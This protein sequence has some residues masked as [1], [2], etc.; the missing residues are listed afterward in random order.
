MSV[1]SIH[2]GRFQ[3]SKTST[4]DH[5]P[6]KKAAMSSPQGSRFSLDSLDERSRSTHLPLFLRLSSRKKSH[7]PAI[8]HQRSRSEDLSSLSRQYTCSR[9]QGKY[10]ATYDLRSDFVDTENETSPAKVQAR[11][12]YGS[13]AVSH[14][15]ADIQKFS[16]LA[17]GVKGFLGKDE[18][19][20]LVVDPKAANTK[21][22]LERVKKLEVM[23][24][25]K[26]T[27]SVD[28]GGLVSWHKKRAT[29]STLA[30]LTSSLAV[31]A[32]IF[33]DQ[34]VNH[35]VS[36]NNSGGKRIDGK[37][38]CNHSGNDIGAVH[39]KG[40]VNLPGP[41]TA[42]NSPK[43][44]KRPSRDF[45]DSFPTW[46]L[47]GGGVEESLESDSANRGE[48]PRL[49]NVGGGA[50]PSVSLSPVPK[51]LAPGTLSLTSGPCHRLSDAV[52]PA[53]FPPV[54]EG[55][56]G[57]RAIKPYSSAQQVLR[58]SRA[59]RRNGRKDQYDTPEDD[60][61]VL[62]LD[63]SQEA[64]GSALE[65]DLQTQKPS[66]R[67]IS[68]AK[69]GG[70]RSS[71]S[72]PAGISAAERSRSLIPPRKCSNDSLVS[73]DS[74][75]TESTRFVRPLGSCDRISSFESGAST[76]TAFCTVPRDLQ[77]EHHEQEAESSHL[78]K[79]L[80]PRSPL[81]RSKDGL[82]KSPQKDQ[83]CATSLSGD[84]SEGS[85]TTLDAIEAGLPEAQ[86]PPKT[87][88]AKKYDV[89]DRTPS[90]SRDIVR[91]REYLRSHPRSP[92]SPPPSA[93]PT[94]PL[95]AVPSG[96][97]PLRPKKR[98][99]PTYLMAGSLK[100][101]SYDPYRAKGERDTTGRQVDSGYKPSPLSIKRDTHVSTTEISSS[102][103]E[104]P[105]SIDVV[106]SAIKDLAT[107]MAARQRQER[108]RCNTA[109][110]QD[111]GKI[112]ERNSVIGEKGAKFIG[113]S[114]KDIK[115]RHLNTARAR[116]END[117]LERRE[118]EYFEYISD[119]NQNESPTTLD[120]RDSQSLSSPPS[121]KGFVP[122]RRSIAVP[123]QAALTRPLRNDSPSRPQ[124]SSN[125]DTPA[126]RPNSI[127][128]RT[129]FFRNVGTQ[130]L[131]LCKNT[132]TAT[133]PRA[134]T[135]PS[136]GTS[137]DGSFTIG[138]PSIKSS[139]RHEV[140]QNMH[141]TIPP[142]HRLRHSQSMGPMTTIFSPAV[143]HESSSDTSAYSYQYPASSKSSLQSN[144]DVKNVSQ[145]NGR[146]TSFSTDAASSASREAV[147]EAK[148]S[149]L[150]FQLQRQRAL[151]FA[152]MYPQRVL[153]MAEQSG[154]L[155]DLDLSRPPTLRSVMSGVD[156]TPPPSAQWAGMGSE[157]VVTA[158]R[159][160]SAGSQYT[161]AQSNRSSQQ[162]VSG[163]EGESVGS[164]STRGLRKV[165]SSWAVVDRKDEG[166]KA[167]TK[168]PSVE[169]M[170]NGFPRAS[171]WSGYDARVAARMES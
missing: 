137:N 51:H 33:E 41:T 3:I 163:A 118:S 98:I 135:G 104:R 95:P 86:S 76:L 112:G 12:P 68:N 136:T 117:R 83:S 129:S 113:R 62:E 161:T 39:Y 155:L 67:Y 37:D 120:R 19:P 142:R 54:D 10:K 134:S 124:S 15:I 141:I 88:S 157:R 17:A 168:G 23:E 18:A 156:F 82:R 153:D 144:N 42:Q 45:V 116:A 152:L 165:Q 43:K 35:V 119:T 72:I 111:L 65:L 167:Q 22:A 31:E 171:F 14:L 21:E 61:E 75:F 140:G 25:G 92:I 5:L 80:P 145:K 58:P 123:I 59:P 109:D 73:S 101:E 29:Q 96:L 60:V 148:C 36:R 27:A 126:S 56:H 146:A 63:C 69:V 170:L 1:S 44:E 87:P 74:K 110:C 4:H 49:G 139:L 90:P 132:A 6:C 66:D 20:A 13:P 81:A 158:S 122:E 11:H 154:E 30:P 40:I 162:S 169:E 102:D 84:E 99:A 38:A 160:P 147:L 127:R 138:E 46:F 34:C 64:S 150:E 28:F 52:K 100:R 106:N 24:N 85:A 131:L 7:V 94:D 159:A 57:V 16:T 149:A 48:D 164:G 32:R 53:A 143:R 79:A 103:D 50:T 114:R 133:A 107:S 89:I 125:A 97:S 108:N 78:S 91:F 130:E 121:D 128:R 47:Q 8:R 2:K 9:G 115:M 77:T 93:P 71:T 151:T 26:K 55:L 70:S 166:G 105:S